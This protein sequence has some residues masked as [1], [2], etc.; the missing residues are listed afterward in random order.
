MQT[1]F[2]KLEPEHPARD[3]IDNLPLRT[4]STVLTKLD[5][6]EDIRPISRKLTF[7]IFSEGISFRF[8]GV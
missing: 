2:V 4:E 8:I 3:L 6:P 1:D 5:F 7:G